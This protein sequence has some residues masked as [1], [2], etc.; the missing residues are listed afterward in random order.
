MFNDWQS[1]YPVESAEVGFLQSATITTKPP[2]TSVTSP[3]NEEED[4]DEADLLRE[5]LLK[6]VAKKRAAKTTDKKTSDSSP[7]SPQSQ[8]ISKSSQPAA[9]NKLGSS[10]RDLKTKQMQQTH[11]I[12]SEYNL[13]YV[14]MHV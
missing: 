7:S 10:T 12:V 14:L 2:E 1:T 8:Q 9:K 6:S 3:E 5:I 13:K 4:D 11:N